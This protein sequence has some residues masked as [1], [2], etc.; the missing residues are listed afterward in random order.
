MVLLSTLN[1]LLWDRNPGF[2]KSEIG[3]FSDFKRKSYLMDLKSTH[4]QKSDFQESGEVDRFLKMGTYFQER[5]G[6]LEIG[7]CVTWSGFWVCPGYWL[8]ILVAVEQI[9][10][11]ITRRLV[12]QRVAPAARVILSQTPSFR[13]WRLLMETMAYWQQVSLSLPRCIYLFV[14]QRPRTL[15][16]QGPHSSKTLSSRKCT[17]NDI[18]KRVGP[19]EEIQ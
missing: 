3:P 12:A 13:R 6:S 15:V 4:S 7:L 14:L 19:R 5:S 9:Y 2:L 1:H 17:P 11:Q 8:L 16:P 10:D 18:P